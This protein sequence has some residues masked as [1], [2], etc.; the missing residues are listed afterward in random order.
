MQSPKTL[1]NSQ[2]IVDEI[3]AYLQR[4]VADTVSEPA[5]ARIIKSTLITIA[6]KQNDVIVIPVLACQAAGGNVDH[7]IPVAA[8][9]FSFQIAAR[10]LDDV[11]DGD[12]NQKKYG[13]CT[14]PCIVNLSTGFMGIG[15]LILASLSDKLSAKQHS[16]LVQNFYRTMLDMSGAQ[17]LDIIHASIPDSDT[18][19]RH[20]QGKSG[21]FF[22]VGVQSGAICAT[23]NTSTL[24]RYYKF[25]YHLGI[26]LQ[27]VN[28]YH[29][30]FSDGPH[31]D[32]AAGKRTAPIYF[33][34]EFAPPS[35][36]ETAF[37]LLKQAVYSQNARARI[38]QI[39]QE[40]GANLYLHAE[41]ARH[42]NLAAL[43]LSPV[44]DPDHVM[45][46][47][48]DRLVPIRDNHLAHS[49]INHPAHSLSAP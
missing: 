6:S 48:L 21:A 47:L 40:Q 41:I 23:M 14:T 7:A 31:S 36:T 39:A 35:V 19:W 24:E 28:D 32:L 13:N 9:W 44:E 49:V 4:C 3:F 27:L 12:I 37:T 1:L 16:A 45:Q 26:A 42:R 20:I 11:E 29:G 43:A 2:A 8:A 10:L 33:I 46:Q 18:Y 38:R 22:G 25:G 17:H 5:Y 30:F 15:N 34:E